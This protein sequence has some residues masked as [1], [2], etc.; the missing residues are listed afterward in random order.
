MSLLS[1]ISQILRLA[2]PEIIQH[3]ARVHVWDTK[4]RNEEDRT[5]SVGHVSIEIVKSFNPRITSNNVIERRYISLR[6]KHSILVNPFLFFLPT[7]AVN[8]PS[9]EE[10]CRGESTNDIPRPPDRVIPIKLN[11]RQYVSM[12]KK[13]VEIQTNVQKQTLLYHLFPGASILPV[14]QQLSTRT[15][16]R[17][18]TECPFSSQPMGDERHQDMAAMSELKASHCALTVRDVLNAGN[19]P[20]PITSWVP[21]K[22]TPTEL[23]NSLEKTLEEVD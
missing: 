23:A 7:R 22:V 5:S 12:T 4:V 21:W 18:M 11:R 19:I 6:P 16:Y 20:T 9:V 1:G 2:S 3:T 14:A 8:C 13:A 10:D 15:S 17:A